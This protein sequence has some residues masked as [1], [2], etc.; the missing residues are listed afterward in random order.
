[1]VHPEIKKHIAEVLGID[2]PEFQETLF[3]EYCNS[4]KEI[5]E[6]LDAATASSDYEELRKLGHKLKGCALTIGHGVARADIVALEEAAREKNG[7]SC[8]AQLEK[9]RGHYMAVTEGL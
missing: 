5:L 1:M 6:Q 8:R 7:S 2:D 3:V 4:F 9:V